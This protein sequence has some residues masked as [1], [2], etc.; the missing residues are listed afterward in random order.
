M[1]RLKSSIL[2]TLSKDECKKLIDSFNT[3]SAILKHLNLCPA[4]GNLKTLRKVFDQ[5]SLNYTKFSTGLDHNKG[6]SFTNPIIN[7]TDLFTNNSIY[8]RKTVK[9]RILSKK[10]IP[11]KCEQCGQEPSW[12]GKELVLVLDHINGISNDNR[13]ENLRFLCPNCNAQQETFCGKHKKPRH[14]KKDHAK[15]LEKLN[16]QT[17]NK[18][19]ARIKEYNIDFS[20]FGW[21]GEIA[22]L[23]NTSHTSIRRFMKKYMPDFY[24]TCYHRKNQFK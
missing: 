20:K 23:E 3:F 10:L 2:W 7:D 22:I 12:N 24:N 11:Y 19:I 17:I 16:M 1:T 5:Y 18:K 13:L 15:I 9:H 4:G 21:V 8:S 6:K 14:I